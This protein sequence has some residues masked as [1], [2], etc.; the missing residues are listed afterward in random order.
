MGRLGVDLPTD[1]VEDEPVCQAS[2]SDATYSSFNSPFDVPLP[3]FMKHQRD[4]AMIIAV[5]R[6]IDNEIT[7]LI[8]HAS[9]CA[10]MPTLYECR[11]AHEGKSTRSYN[12][13]KSN[14][15]YWMVQALK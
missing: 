11:D 7:R 10:A 3:A 8:H 14:L 15:Q 4:L 2:P 12:G 1:L 6:G 13:R 5:R 9:P